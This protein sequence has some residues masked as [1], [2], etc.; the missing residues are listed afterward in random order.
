MKI[1]TI[2]HST[3][4]K[5]EFISLLKAYNIQ[6]LVDVRSY[7]GSRHVPQFNKEDMEKW[8]AEAGFKYI[9]LKDLGGRRKSNIEIDATLIE[10][11]NQAAFKNYAGYSLTSEYRDGIEQLIG[12]A[13]E[14]TVCYMCAEAVPWR[15]HRLLI[16]NTLVTRGFDVFHIMSKTKT[17]SHEL[18]RYGAKPVIN[19]GI[20]TYPAED[21][22]SSPIKK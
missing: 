2:G 16:S 12:I 7:P 8:V 4:S 19:N 20:I 11:W 15:C 21:S 10:G 14:S 5:E 17:I 22:D 9:H 13:S 6:V 18:G 3:H 1:Y